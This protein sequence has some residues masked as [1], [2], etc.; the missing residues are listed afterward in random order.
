MRYDRI[1]KG[2]FLER[3]NRFVA[4]VLLDGRKEKV[5][6]KNTGRCAELLLP[7]TE[8]YLEESGNPERTTAYDLVAVKKGDRIVNVDSSAPNKAVSA[9]TGGHSL[10]LRKR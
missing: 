9:L 1:R 2:I 4:Y 7:G 5:H 8:V 6:V 3:P 10:N